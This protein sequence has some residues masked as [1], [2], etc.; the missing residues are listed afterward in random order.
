MLR[1]ARERIDGADASS[2]LAHAL[3]KPVGWLFAHAD[4]I[5]DTPTRRRF[6]ALVDARVAGEPVAYLTGS[7]GFWTLDL[8]V[9]PDTLIPRP[10]TELL[11]ELALARIPATGSVRIAD[12]GTGSGAIALAIAKE[13]PHAHVVATDASSAALSVAQRNAKANAIGNVGFRQGSWLLP[14]AGERFDL[15]ASNPPYIAE[16]DPHLAS[17]QHEPDLALASGADGLEAIREIVAAAQ[18][19]LRAGGWL[20]LEHGWDQG[21]AVRALMQSADYVE[22][23]TARD[24][25]ER[26]RVTL[27]RVR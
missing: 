12:L 25:E 5:I 11:V 16:G 17:L 20:L 2:L 1:Q 21:N 27:G 7:R 15:I 26:D 14:L 4:E 13:R 8:E 18:D 24:L 10:E 9:T 3:D 19:H 22:V 23:S 6:A